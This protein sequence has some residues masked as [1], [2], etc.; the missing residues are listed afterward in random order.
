VIDLFG[1]KAR[2]DAARW[3]E[4]HDSVHLHASE[5]GHRLVRMERALIRTR[6]RMSRFARHAIRYRR[7]LQDAERRADAAARVA[8]RVAREAN[9]LERKLKEAHDHQAALAIEADNAMK[10]HGRH[11]RGG[12]M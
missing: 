4:R 7:Q 12:C 10:G 9:E 8:G 6:K 5:L 3:R 11:G 2:R 1:I